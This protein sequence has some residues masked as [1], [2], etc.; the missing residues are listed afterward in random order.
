MD[1]QA[2]IKS[3][4]VGLIAS[5]AMFILMQVA[6]ATGIVPFHTAP[7][8]AFLIALG[9]DLKVAAI[10]VHF[11][12]GT[13]WSILIVLFYSDDL[14]FGRC[15]SLSI[16]LWIILMIVLSPVIGWGFF[17]GGE[18]TLLK[19]EHRMYIESGFKYP[20]VTLIIHLVYGSILG[21]LNPAWAIRHI[22]PEED[23]Q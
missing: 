10:V 6:L 16:L 21:W 13:F 12:Y 11:L 14:N 3:G 8:H 4:I 22:E 19:P 17:G 18:N 15:I 5:L 1:T 23:E 20:L 9:I 7:S 2:V